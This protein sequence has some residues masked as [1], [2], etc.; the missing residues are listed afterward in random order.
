VFLK[1]LRDSLARA[2]A[3]TRLDD[4]GLPDTARRLLALAAGSGA[5]SGEVATFQPS[6]VTRVGEATM[7]V[8][9][10]ATELVT[11]L[12]QA[13][14]SSGAAPTG[15]TRVRGSDV[16]QLIREA[17]AG[18]LAIVA[19]V[20]GLVGAIIAFVSA[21]QLRRFGTG[22]YVA[23]LLGIATAREMAAIITAVVMAGRTGGAY[24]AQLATMQGNEE[25]DAL[26]VFA[27]P[28]FDFLVLP[29]IVALLTMMPLLYLYACAA[30]LLGGLLV[31][32]VTL[33][34]TTMAF[35][36][37]LRGAVANRHFVI[38]LVKSIVF[39]AL[40]AM[41]GCH[42]GLRAGRSSAD[43]GYAATTAVV[44]GIVGIIMLDALFA[45]CTDALGI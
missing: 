14:L 41:L 29:R 3:E 26:K 12:G 40:V 21:I 44:A 23:D 33:D 35:L 37:E 5:E 34:I 30:A 15:K 7:S 39:G 31:S 22:I 28:V 32:N 16:M 36:Q 38:G 18:A 17:G 25:I 43:V 13:V 1:M 6:V 20:N 11:L 24:A 2:P 19:I 42:I 8:S 4:S 27:I 10:Q 9:T 45:V